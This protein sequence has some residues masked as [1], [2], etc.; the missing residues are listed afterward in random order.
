MAD[1]IPW[2]APNST[3][4]GQQFSAREVAAGEPQ[5]IDC[6]VGDGPAVMISVETAQALAALFFSRAADG[7][8]FRDGEEARATADIIDE[9]AMILVQCAGLGGGQ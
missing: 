4:G 1:V 7:F 2:K 9:C 5:M 3:T 8:R 6:T